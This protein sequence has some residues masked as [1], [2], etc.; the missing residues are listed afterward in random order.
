VGAR[1]SPPDANRPILNDDGSMEQSFR[2]WTSLVTQRE[3]IIGSGNPEGVF[4]AIQG[5]IYMND[6]GTSGSILYVKRDQSIAGDTKQG[7]VLV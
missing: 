3:M 2:A 6:A 7:W 5:A 4:E 1:V